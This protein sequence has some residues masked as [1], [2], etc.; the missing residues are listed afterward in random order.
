[1]KKIFAFA[2]I[3]VFACGLL[4]LQSCGDE[5]DKGESTSAGEDATPD[6]TPAPTPA[7][8]PE[9]TP[10]PT[11]TEKPPIITEVVLK[12]TFT[13]ED[14]MFRA[15]SQTSD[16]RVEDGILKM[17]STG[18]DPNIMSTNANIGIDTAE[19]DYIRFWIKNNSDGYRCQLFFVTNE[20]TAWSEAQSMRSEY[21]YSDG[22]EWETLE[23]DTWDCSVWEGTIKQLRFD[24]LEQEGDV[25]IEYM[26][27]EKI[28]K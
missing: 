24:Y 16:F 19:V 8:T 21:Y 13:E 11:T 22:E 3:A 17:T 26:T 14:K 10:P 20:D 7:P 28:V 18:G 2:L 4:V 9:P 5:A 23:F 12:W 1:M 6:P 15:S 25:E 27:F